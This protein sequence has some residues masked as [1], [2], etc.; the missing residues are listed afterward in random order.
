MWD[1]DETTNDTAYLAPMGEL[2]SAFCEY[3]LEINSVFLP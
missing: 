2:W 1:I 3:L